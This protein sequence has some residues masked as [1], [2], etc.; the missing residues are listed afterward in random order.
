MQL[1]ISD[2][3]PIFCWIALP[4]PRNRALSPDGVCALER[5][6][7]GTRLLETMSAHVSA[8]LPSRHKLHVCT[9]FATCKGRNKLK[10]AFMQFFYGCARQIMA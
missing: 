10:H 1:V 2:G 5:A 4:G 3:Q 8:V 7:L 6:Q 9:I